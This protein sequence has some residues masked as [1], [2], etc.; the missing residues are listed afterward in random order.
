M[1]AIRICFGLLAAATI[2]GFAQR[3]S[4]QTCDGCGCHDRCRAVCRPVCTT[5]TVSEICWGSECEDFCMPGEVRHDCR[6]LWRPWTICC[7]GCGSCDC[8]GPCDGQC[9][10]CT[11]GTNCAAPGGS[12][13]VTRK[14]LMFRVVEYEIPVTRWEIDYLCEQCCDGDRPA[15][16][17]PQPPAASDAV[18]YDQDTAPTIHVAPVF[19]SQSPIGEL[20]TLPSAD[21]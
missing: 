19:R 12:R 18:Y 9:R 1:K 2:G 10:D 6:P 21:R 11:C 15:D 7:Q 13:M 3:T 16:G 14:K 5:K 20:F 8:E 4:A 17:A